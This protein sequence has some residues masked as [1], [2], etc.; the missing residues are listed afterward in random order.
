MVFFKQKEA[1]NPR[2]KR[3]LG[4]NDQVY[5]DYACSSPLVR[6][7]SQERFLQIA[8]TGGKSLVPGF[9]EIFTFTDV[10]APIYVRKLPEFLHLL[11][12]YEP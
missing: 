5:L 12:R 2:R 4:D 6:C 7:A 3:T 9:G 8:Q 10:A 11:E 1:Q